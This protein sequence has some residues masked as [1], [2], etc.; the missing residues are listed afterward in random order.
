MERINI[1][2]SNLII[3]PLWYHLQNIQQT[4]TGFGEKLST[5]YMV[6]YLGRK[7]RIY[8]SQHSNVGT[9]YINVKGEKVI[10]EI[11]YGE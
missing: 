6:E 2:E 10:V 9:A 11:Y 3:N 1:K 7:R 8:V 5:E 4:A